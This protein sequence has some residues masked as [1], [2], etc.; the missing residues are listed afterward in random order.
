[1]VPFIYYTIV[2]IVIIIYMAKREKNLSMSDIIVIG[3]TIMFSVAGAPN[4]YGINFGYNKLDVT[5]LLLYLANAVI[6]PVGLLL[7]KRI[8]KESVYLKS[9]NGCVSD[10]FLYLLIFFV[11]I[12]AAGFFFLIRDSIPLFMLFQGRSAY[13]VAVARLRVTHNLTSYYSIPFIFRYYTLVFQFCGLYTFSVLFVKYLYEPP[14]YKKAFLLYFPIVILLQCYSTEKAPIIYLVL[15][16]VIDLYL[17]K[18]KY[19]VSSFIEN[20]WLKIDYRNQK[21]AKRKIILGLVFGAFFFLFI[22]TMF[23]GIESFSQGF[24]SMIKRAFLQQSDSIYLQKITLDNVYNGC[25]WG[26]GITLTG[27]DSIIGRSPISLSRMAYASLYSSY[28]EDGGGGTGG[29]LGIFD[30]YANFG[31]LIAMVLVFCIACVTGY[32]DKKTSYVIERSPN[33]VLPIAY[34]S[35]LTVLFFEGYLGHFQTFF[36]LPFIIAPSMIITIFITY[37]FKRIR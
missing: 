31:F 28:L 17:V 24:E 20:R 8:K 1:M 26:K 25:L 3:V 29:S 36:Q 19:W 35:M 5:L 7:G 30:F 23:M 12:Y 34:Y 11:I 6:I 18:I 15:V 21:K 22:Y 10:R 9:I 27:I 13:D 37:C 4:S 32:V 33:R 14:K 16:I 2:I